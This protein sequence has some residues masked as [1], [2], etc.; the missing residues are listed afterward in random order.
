MIFAFACSRLEFESKDNLEGE[1]PPLGAL[2]I[3]ELASET[4]NIL[5]IQ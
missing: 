1:V 4:E 3:L 2:T 5:T